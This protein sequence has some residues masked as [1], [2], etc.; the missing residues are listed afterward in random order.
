MAEIAL[1]F[2]IAASGVGLY[3]IYVTRL[4]CFV[5]VWVIQCIFLYDASERVDVQKKRKMDDSVLIA[6][7]VEPT[8]Q[9]TRKQLEMIAGA[10]VYVKQREKL[11]HVSIA[12]A[13]VGDHLML[14]LDNDTKKLLNIFPS[15]TQT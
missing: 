14:G 8:E 10:L 11:R 7:V 1:A 3:A 2:L 15:I 12:G 6:Q 9:F 4:E 5:L 13:P